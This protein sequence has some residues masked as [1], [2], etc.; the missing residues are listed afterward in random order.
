[1]SRVEKME[2]EKIVA[3]F[4][5]YED[6]G[7]PEHQVLNTGL[8]HSESY[9]SVP[10]AFRATLRVRIGAVCRSHGG[11]MRCGF[12]HSLSPH[13]EGQVVSHSNVGLFS[14]NLLRKRPATPTNTCL[15]SASSMYRLP[16]VFDLPINFSLIDIIFN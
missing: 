15:S 4:V 16:Q 6:L 9:Y 2:D 1:M 3:G 5:P 8:L 11:S 14:G 13:R 12:S 7:I 10:D